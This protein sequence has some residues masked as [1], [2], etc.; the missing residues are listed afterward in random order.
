[1]LKVLI[2]DDD[3]KLCTAI[4]Q[5]N[6]DKF[7]IDYITEISNKNV[8]TLR[9][10]I[11]KNKYS[12]IVFD[13][14]I[15][16]INGFELFKKLL[17]LEGIAT[18]FLSGASTTEVRVMSLKSGVDDFLMKP[19][20][21]L[22]LQVRMEKTLKNKQT[23]N[24]EYLGNYKIDNNTQQI[25]L[26]EKKLDLAPMTAKLLKYLLKNQGRNLTRE[27]LMTNVWSYNNE[28]GNR[29]VDTSI[30]LL[31]TETKDVNIV[32]VRGIGYKYEKTK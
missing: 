16:K 5:F 1:M 29:T 8:D 32:T 27:E 15:G 11:I 12:L 22:E 24:F 4:K 31:R 25:Y 7:N 26:F 3:E 18:I 20:D 9:E 14:E 2:I 23:P 10:S 19:I 21:L 6:F 13:L 28:D 30:N 17:P